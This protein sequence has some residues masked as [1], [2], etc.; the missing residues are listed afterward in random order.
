MKYNVIIWDINK[1]EFVPYDIFPYLKR[2]FIQCKR[3]PYTFEEY[4]KWIQKEAFYQWWGRCEYEV[5]LSSWPGES[6]KEKID[7]YYQIMNN[8]DTITELFMQEMKDFKVIVTD[9]PD[10]LYI[11][12]MWPDV[13]KLMEY[14][15]F[16]DNAYLID[17]DSTYF[18]KYNWLKDKWN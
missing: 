2:K 18:V 8:I 17:D 3:I 12:V 4:K 15:D 5:I 6:K 10:E 11:P 13:Q 14:K 16:H 7:V 1:K 9:S